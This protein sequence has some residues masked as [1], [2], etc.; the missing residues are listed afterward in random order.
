MKTYRS[1]VSVTTAASVIAVC[2]QCATAQI[3]SW[4]FNDD[5]GSVVENHGTLGGDYALVTSDIQGAKADL[6]SAPG[7]GVSGAASDRA[8]DLTSATEMGGKGPSVITQ[9]KSSFEL[10]NLQALTIAGWYRIPDRDNPN[11]TIFRASGRNE[12]PSGWLL[13]WDK[14]GKLLLSIGDGHSLQIAAS[15][16][17]HHSGDDGWN[18]FAV[19][20]DGS[21]AKFFSGNKTV[22]SE[23]VAQVPLKVT[24]N[25]G[26]AAYSLGQ[27]NTVSG[28]FK[29]LLDNIVIFDK[30][31]SPEELENLRKAA[32]N[33]SK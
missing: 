9:S 28:A 25:P 1:I 16:E 21:E 10:S 4:N 32:L 24:M 5:G 8:L 15:K 26:P 2:I 13:G 12:N 6:R 31:L 23:E 33:P 30:A 3:V 18:F 7:T 27:S 20:W 14:K 19:T 17:A 29:G 22:D 11:G